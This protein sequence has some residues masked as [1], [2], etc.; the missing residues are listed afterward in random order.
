MKKYKNKYV[1]KHIYE[2]ITKLITDLEATDF[3]YDI[4]KGDTTN[5]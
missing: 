5:E 4:D 1:D 2:E 3:I